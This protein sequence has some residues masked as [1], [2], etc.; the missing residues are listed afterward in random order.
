MERSKKSGIAWS[1]IFGDKI[2]N[3]WN[4][5]GL[6]FAIWIVFVVYLSLIQFSTPHLPGNDGFYHI[7]MAYLMRTE[8]LVLDFI[9][10][11]FSIINPLQFNDHQF[12]FHA[13]LIPF[14][15]GD[16]ILGAKIAS[17]F[18]ASISFLCVW[19]IFKS[20]KI[21]YDAIWAFGLMGVSEAFIFR[22]MLTRTQSLSLIILLLAFSW[23]LEKKNKRLIFLGFFYVWF[24]NAFP[25]L[26]VIAGCYFVANFLLHRKFTFQPLLYSFAGIV[27]GNL[28]NPYFP[29]NLFFT[30]SHIIPKILETTTI[31]VGSEWYPY[32]TVQLI[33]NS[34][35]ALLLFIIGSFALGLDEKRMDLRTA[36]SF[37]V[38]VVFGIM[39]F[40]SR[41]FIEYYPPFALVF[42][43]FSCA[44]IIET[45]KNEA[46]IGLKK[47]L[48]SLL[49]LGLIL[50][51]IWITF[52]T[53]KENFQSTKSSIIYSEASDWL[54]K[55]TPE[56]SRIFQT[57]W[58]D[59]PRLFYF[60]TH[61]TYLIGLDPTFM[62][63]YDP[64][65]FELYVEITQGKIE[66]PSEIIRNKFGC[67]YIHTDLI[68]EKFSR[69]ANNDP[70]IKEVFRT[71]DSI[72]YQII[73]G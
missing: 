12:L 63:Q 9:W 6:G 2:T 7:K 54:K 1:K 71:D 40:Q 50:P 37:G 23:I 52:Q 30:F 5:L 31:N 57:D 16:L 17:I 61:N 45:W 72:I 66:N 68:H 51:S 34:F 44:P 43:A 39:L 21:P 19:Y 64:E 22:M 13:I 38:S 35:L 41:R 67:D 24:Y 14:T 36:T 33:K 59:F 8:G 18:F 56:G 58:D 60:N 48:P 3:Y 28:I 55:N 69:V 49:L 46:N 73:D 47:Y 53:S 10:L 11:P 15:F 27:L 70:K 26:L 42:A 29:K 25:L 62:Q 20:Q 4:R 65:L 32:D